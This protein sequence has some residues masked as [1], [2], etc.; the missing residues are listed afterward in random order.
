MLSDATGE[1]RMTIAA[2]QIAILGCVLLASVPALTAQ[3]QQE[4]SIPKTNEYKIGQVWTADRGITVTI[5]AV[6]D[7]RKV[8]KVVHVRIDRIPVQ[9]CGDIHLIR[10]IEHLA[11]T[12]KVMR[13]S[14]LDLLK[15]NVDLPESYLDAYRKWEEQKK[16]DIVK[17]PI[18]K[19][20]LAS[21]SV[22][23]PM[24][25]NFVPSQA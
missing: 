16:H 21:G 8:G 20:I 22:M 11:L 19:A 18:Q 4:D 25:C 9:T 3:S 24:I 14:G 13:K 2:S 15:D 6:E 17:V 10:T 23:G 7:I 5:L 1:W 12:E